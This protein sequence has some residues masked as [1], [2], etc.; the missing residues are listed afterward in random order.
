MVDSQILSKFDKT[1]VELTVIEITVAT[2]A[3][4]RYYALLQYDYNIVNCITI[5]TIT[6]L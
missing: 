3:E 4:D 1:D 2:E 5:C 6:Q